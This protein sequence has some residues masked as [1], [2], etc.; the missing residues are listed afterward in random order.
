MP[1]SIEKKYFVTTSKEV[2]QTTAFSLAGWGQDTSLRR[3]LRRL[4]NVFGQLY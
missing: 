3:I 4:R 1:F 2:S